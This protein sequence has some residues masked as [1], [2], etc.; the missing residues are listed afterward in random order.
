MDD[1]GEF[2]RALTMKGKGA[3]IDYRAA[4][5]ATIQAP[6][7]FDD[8][9]AHKI[10]ITPEAI[11][12]LQKGVSAM[13]TDQVEIIGNKEGVSFQM[14][15]DATKDTFAYKFASLADIESTD[16]NPPNFQYTYLIKNL[17]TLFK[18]N[19]DGYF[20]VTAK[21]LIKFVVNGLD[22]YIPYRT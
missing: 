10:R 17:L 6:K 2:V 12:L 1:K 7:K 18:Q 15:E 11:L 21:G 16:G 14:T 4:N 9:V 3:K 20:F 22:L 13:K 19:P 5:P 8:K